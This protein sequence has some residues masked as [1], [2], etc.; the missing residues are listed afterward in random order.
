MQ[1]SHRWRILLSALFVLLLFPRPAHACFC[2]PPETVDEAVADST[3][4]FRA[5]MVE[6]F[7][8]QMAD[9]LSRLR[10]IEFAVHEV[11]KG[12][13]PTIVNVYTGSGGGDCGYRF[14]DGGEHLIYAYDTEIGL[15]TSICN[16]TARIEDAAEDLRLLGEGRSAFPVDGHIVARIA[17]YLIGVTVWLAFAYWLWHRRSTKHVVPLLLVIFLMA[18]AVMEA[19]THM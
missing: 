4:V 18:C 11:W 17:P 19:T 10:R 12:G 8:E 15:A 13:V 2:V 9:P 3:A 7:E 5:T 16:R 1:Q 14:Q 6:S